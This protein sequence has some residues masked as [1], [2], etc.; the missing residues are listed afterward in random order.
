M[1]RLRSSEVRMVGHTRSHRIGVGIIAAF[2]S[3]FLFAAALDAQSAGQTEERI[4]VVAHLPL[5]EMHVNQ[6]FSQQRGNKYYLYLHRPNRQAFAL[7][8][9]THPEKPVLLERATLENASGGE[10]QIAKP[11][12]TLAVAV[13]P[14]A[15]ATGGAPQAPAAPPKA[16]LPRETVRLM[17]LS[18]PKHPKILKTFSG[19]TSMLPDEPRHLLYLVN[20]E[21]LWIVSH[22]ETQAMPFCTSTSALMNAPNCQ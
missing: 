9:V 11:E 19:V 8:D 13:T 22:R 1:F 6:M 5:P 2:S 7:V 14:E 12:S 15:E 18:D 21:G 20:S 16:A 3:L 10:I 17:D 4:K